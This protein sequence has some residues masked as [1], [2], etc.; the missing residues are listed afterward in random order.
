M[1]A[2]EHEAL[3]RDLGVYVLGALEPAERDRLERHLAGCDTCRD[4]VASLAVLP[5][6]LARAATDATGIPE[7]PPLGPIVQRLAEDRRRTRRRDRLGAAAA[8]VAATLALVAVLAGPS[9][10]ATPPGERYVADSASVTA[11]VEQRAWGMTVHIQA[12]QLPDRDGYIAVAVT[13][14]GHR[15]QVASWAATGRAVTVEGACYLAPSDVDR[16][17]I[18]AA[19]GEEVLAVLHR[20]PS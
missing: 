15:T 13:P 19:R 8:A 1:S 4:E 20:A 3:R 12:E 14:N 7:L 10:D 18:V 16:L 9:H 5:G 11:S 2:G 17:E 6:L